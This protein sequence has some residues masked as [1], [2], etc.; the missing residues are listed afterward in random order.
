MALEIFACL[1]CFKFE[2]EL[3]DAIEDVP[4]AQDKTHVT[5]SLV[6]RGRDNSV[7]LPS[8]HETFIADSTA[9]GLD[10]SSV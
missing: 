5:E 6:L 8:K 2:L 10:R 9:C 3:L 7:Q 4:F 1:C